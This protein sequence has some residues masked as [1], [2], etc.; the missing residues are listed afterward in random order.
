MRITESNIKDLPISGYDKGLLRSLLCDVEE[1]NYNTPLCSRNIYI[2]WIEE[3]TEYS[4]ERTDP[5]PDY[6]GMFR[7]RRED[8]ND[9]LGVEMTLRD[10]DISLCLLHN[11]L[12]C[13]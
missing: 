8:N 13:D 6:Y 9:Y 10:L 3:H 4:P 5:C 2:E 7:V 12:I 11:Y 1:I